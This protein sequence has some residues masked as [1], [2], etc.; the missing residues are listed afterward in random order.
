MSTA[1]TDT[2]NDQIVSDYFSMLSLDVSGAHYN[3]AE[4]RRLL[5]AKIGRSEGSIEYKHQNISAVLKAIGED[6]IPGYKPAFNYQNALED[7]VLRWLEANPKWL[8]PSTRRAPTVQTQI[9]EGEI[10]FVGP[11]PTLRNEPEPIELEKT[12]AV[13]RKLDIA[14]RDERNRK[15]GRAGEEKALSYE[16]ASLVSAGRQDL[17]GRIVWV[18]EEIGDGAG[19][20][21]A[22]FEPDGRERLIEVKTTNG[23]ERTPFW[24]SKNELS[25]ADEHR[26]SWVLMRLYNFAR[27][28]AAFELRPPL[29]A[30]VQ[31]T[32]TT[33]QANFD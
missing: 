22:S 15:L 18:S 26:K 30:H 11:A 7:A 32:A 1:W 33:Y 29:D 9:Q 14:G 19:Y 13:A 24:I 2:E 17:A 5:C 12:L 20:D 10:F 28:P 25:V 31:L 8:D 27:R 16:R 3:K 6:W 23:W 21:I 4:H